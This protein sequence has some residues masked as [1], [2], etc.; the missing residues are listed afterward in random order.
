[1][2]QGSLFG[3]PA[4]RAMPERAD[5]VALAEALPGLRLGTSSWS[6]PGWRGHV[7]RDPVSPDLLSS[8]GLEAYAQ[9][10]L[11]RTV[12]IDRT[13]YRLP[14]PGVLAA[15]ARQVPE[16]FR[17]VVKAPSVVGSSKLRGRDNPHAL[18]PAWVREE[19]LARFVELG[20]R[21][22][23]V[24][25]QLPPQDPDAFGDRFYHRLAEVL[26][27]Q[28]PWV[29]EVRT[30]EWVTPDLRAVL[31]ETHTVPC[32]SVHPRMPDLRTQWRVLDLGRV[33]ELHIRW[34][35]GS[36]L[37]YEGAR[38]RYAPFDRM[39]DPDPGTREKLARS[40]AWMLERDRPVWVIANNKAEGCAPL[41]LEALARA[42]LGLRRTA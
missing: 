35:L 10:P 22:G 32:L 41:T 9:H 34:N 7:W 37:D 17:F 5:L 19:A 39:V 26:A 25:L 24:L 13:Y 16:G 38:D 40:I 29:V 4:V 33:P 20:D 31:A 8:D 12:S 6:F 21:L 36:G 14:E 3:G 23:A 28:L 2:S 11:F 1:M 18:D 15:Y 30:P 42:V 27:V